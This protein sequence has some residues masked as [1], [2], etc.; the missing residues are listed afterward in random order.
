MGGQIRGHRKDDAISHSIISVRLKRNA[1]DSNKGRVFHTNIEI[2]LAT[3]AA[4]SGQALY[5][6]WSGGVF[7][8]SDFRSGTSCWVILVLSRTRRLCT[9]CFCTYPCDGV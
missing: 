7:C 5:E 1:V 6:K 2:C 9:C 8:T 4:R 3:L